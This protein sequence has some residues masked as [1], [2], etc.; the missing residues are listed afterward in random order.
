MH[1]KYQKLEL[2][3]ILGMKT[4]IC[5]FWNPKKHIATLKHAF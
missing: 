1:W 5:I 4:E 2:L 3:G